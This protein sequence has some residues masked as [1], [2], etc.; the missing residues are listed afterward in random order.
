M[1]QQV[2]QGPIGSQQVCTQVQAQGVQQSMVVGQVPNQGT[3]QATGQVQATGVQ[4]QQPIFLCMFDF[5]FYF[6]FYF[7]LV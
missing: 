4:P 5:C 7:Y 1:H 3:N 6:H 2:G